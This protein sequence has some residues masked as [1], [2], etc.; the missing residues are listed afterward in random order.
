MP[1]AAV[2]VAAPWKVAQGEANVQAL[3]SLPVA[4]ETHV[5][6][7]VAEVAKMEAVQKSTATDVSRMSRILMGISS[8]EFE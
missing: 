3:V 1:F 6:K 8:L 4:A 2:L 7:E 5:C